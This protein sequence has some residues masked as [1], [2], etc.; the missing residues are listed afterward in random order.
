MKRKILIVTER[1]AD[2]SKFRPIIKEIIKSK[3]LSYQLIVTGSHFSKDHGYTINEIKKDGFHIDAKFRMFSKNNGDT[4]SDMAFSLGI[5]LQKL[6]K[7]VSKLKPDI[8][9][10]GFDIGANLAVAIVGSHMNIP[11]AHLEAGEVTGTIDEPIRHSISKFAHF[12]FTT[13]SIA[14]KRLIKMGENK[15]LIFTVGNPSLDSILTTKNISKKTLSKEFDIN[16]LEPYVIVLQH[17]VTSE[18]IHIE[19]YFLETLNAIKELDLQA[20]LILG[21]TDTGSAKI[22]KVLKN[23]KMKY[24]KT[25]SFEKYINLLKHADILIGNSSSG[26]MEAP[27]LHIPSINIGTRQNGRLKAKSVFDVPYKKLEIKKYIKKILADPTLNIKISK[28]KNIYGNG[29]SSE[30]IVRILETINLNKI[31]IQKKLTY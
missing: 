21:N 15:K 4:G 19:Q 13:N 6:S 26:K 8:I 22:L 29:D 3:K 25:I 31:P 23:S 12:H 20:I 24:H 9:L 10:S 27:F 1:R 14:T 2:Y 5:A 28:Q 30:K 11:V 17:P 7:I 18:V 16:F